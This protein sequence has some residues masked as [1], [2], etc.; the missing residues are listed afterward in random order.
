[1]FAQGNINNGDTQNSNP[2]A[3][4]KVALYNGLVNSKAETARLYRSAFS[5]TH[6]GAW[7]WGDTKNVISYERTVNSHLPEGLAGGPEGSYTGL[8][9]V[10]SRHE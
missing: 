8:D 5:L 3:R 6:D 10:Q 2:P 4:D 7:E 1:M 9:F